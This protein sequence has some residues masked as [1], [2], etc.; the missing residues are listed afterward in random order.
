MLTKEQQTLFYQKLGEAIK[1]ARIN[2]KHKQESLST[3]LGLNRISVVNIEKGKQKVQL[4]TLIEIAS[5]LNVRIEELVPP[6]E[7]L[8]S[9]IIDTK[10]VK[11]IKKEMEQVDNK[12]EGGVRVTDFVL[13]SKSKS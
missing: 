7:Y 3:H 4:H 8:K 12:D 5:F 10:L 1:T 6:L 2:G 13:F 9:P 11:S